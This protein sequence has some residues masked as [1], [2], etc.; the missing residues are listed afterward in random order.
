MNALD[1][2]VEIVIGAKDRAEKAPE[3]GELEDDAIL[4]QTISEG[5][6][7]LSCYGS[8]EEAEKAKGFVD[9][10][11]S[12]LRKCV[13]GEFE[14]Y[15]DEKNARLGDCVEGVSGSQT[16]PLSNA[17]AMAYRAI[18]IGLANWSRWTPINEARDDIRSLAI[19]KLETSLDEKLGEQ[20]NL[21]TIYALAV[22]LAES[23]DLD[24]AIDYVKS[25]LEMKIPS[26]T[27]GESE[28]VKL[29][30]ERDLVPVWHLLALLLSAKQRYDIAGRACEAA[31]EQFPGDVTIFS[32][33]RRKSTR[34][35]HD[36]ELSREYDDSYPEKD[37]LDHLRGREKERIIEA[38]MTQLALIEVTEG[39]DVA[40]NHSD[41]L[42]SLFA[43]LYEDAEL[44]VNLEHKEQTEQ[45]VPPKTSSGKSFRESIFGR[46]KTNR[47][48][49]RRNGA[50][51]DLGSIQSSHTASAPKIQI[52][53][54]ENNRKPTSRAN[55][56][57]RR[58]FH[59]LHKRDGSTAPLSHE[60]QN[61][62]Q[63][64][65]KVPLNQAEAEVKAV[66][67]E[68]KEAAGMAMSN[69]ASPVSPEALKQ[70]ARQ[71]LPLVSQKSTPNHEP[72]PVG[73]AKPPSE[74]D[75]RLPQVHRFESPTQ[76]L[77][78]FSSIHAQKHAICVLVKI[79]L[80]IGGLY[81]RAS[82]FEDAQGACE[83][84]TKL[85][86]RF[87]SLV[88][89]Q[90][91]SARAFASQ[92]WGI[93]KSCDELWADVYAERGA[94]LLARSQPHE[95]LE[96]YEAAVSRYPDHCKATAGVANLL[97]D[98]WDGNLPAEAPL[99]RLDVDLTK[100]SLATKQE[101]KNLYQINSGVSSTSNLLSKQEPSVPTWTE[102]KLLQ[103]DKYNIQNKDLTPDEI[104]RLA[105]R[106]RAYGLLSAL[107]KSGSSWDDSEAWFALSRA[108]E[109][110]GQVEKM[111]DV[112]WWCVE[113]EDRRP[114]RHW[115]NLGAGGYVL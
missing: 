10:L 34:H 12:Y 36:G 90:E 43:T 89:S 114:I 57:R 79:W 25:A 44:E 60:R 6:L 16:V 17:V 9:I 48:P 80:L 23:R 108:Y 77:T 55:S 15:Q 86:T 11:E 47:L 76:A 99:P 113:L 102:P 88:G 83:E 64:G 112:L 1:S 109:A 63:D 41:Q 71:Q 70:S 13:P 105:A 39:P 68:D 93:N 95:A 92:S 52:G 91:S 45:L 78:R 33:N 106:D 98:I 111:K 50:G 84:A 81:R 37:L 65:N 35:R 3:I 42:L 58:E 72:L 66:S 94:L 38:R 107:T 26:F 69:E 100:V 32:H 56:T 20:Y 51:S 7:L 67:G 22:L 101:S 87:E 19:E 27:P 54:E 74:V 2:Y 110:S 29:T 28:H 18:G 14:P 104:N 82:L 4:L 53:A 115:W 8:Y 97:L 24:S 31:F 30:K 62:S 75:A 85:V 49:D 96:Y 103:S 40:V 46:K 61:V 59:K 21:S 5:I 73:P